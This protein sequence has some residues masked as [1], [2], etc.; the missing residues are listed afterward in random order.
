MNFIAEVADEGTVRQGGGRGR[1]QE[2]DHRPVEGNWFPE[3]QQ[4][5]RRLR[6]E[7]EDT[8]TTA[9]T[10]MTVTMT[11]R[12]EQNKIRKL[13]ETGS[14]IGAAGATTT[15]PA[16][17]D[18]ADQ[19]PQTP[20]AKPLY[21]SQAAKEANQR[22][23]Q[24]MSN[25]REDESSMPT[26]V[27]YGMM[28][29]VEDDGFFGSIHLVREE[30][31]LLPSTFLHA[32]IRS[33]NVFYRTVGF[34]DYGV[35][36]VLSNHQQPIPKASNDETR[37]EHQVRPSVVLCHPTDG[38]TGRR[39]PFDGSLDESVLNT[40]HGQ[41]C[42]GETVSKDMCIRN[43]VWTKSRT[44]TIKD[45]TEHLEEEVCLMDDKC[46]C[47]DLS[48]YFLKNGKGERYALEYGDFAIDFAQQRHKL[49]NPPYGMSCWYDDVHRRM[50][51]VV[52]ASNSM[53][54]KR[55]SWAR[56]RNPF[57]YKGLNECLLRNA[58]D[59][60]N[61]RVD[62]FVIELTPNAE[63]FANLDS[64]H[65]NIL[66]H[67]RNDMKVTN[68]LKNMRRKYGDKP[69]LLLEERLG[70]K[71]DSQLKECEYYWGGRNCGSG[72]R[73]H[74]V[75][76]PLNFTDGSCLAVPDGCN[77]VYYFPPYDKNNDNIR[78]GN[79]GNDEGSNNHDIPWGC[80]I[81]IPKDCS[82]QAGA[83]TTT[84][85]TTNSTTVMKIKTKNK[86]LLVPHQEGLR[87]GEECKGTSHLLHSLFHS[88]DNTIS[89]TTHHAD[90]HVAT[91]Q[92]ENIDNDRYYHYHLHHP[93][94]TYCT[95]VYQV[96]ILALGM[97]L[98]LLLGGAIRQQ[99]LSKSRRRQQR[100]QQE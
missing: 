23:W 66:R 76:Q 75:A 18:D 90:D 95:S 45:A 5:R 1:T 2:Q 55:D 20:L 96:M 84:T 37:N 87:D 77:E 89:M 74:F 52:N 72:F 46:R 67:L 25:E 97:T 57:K 41:G 68:R 62:A 12:N 9:A 40:D 47:N 64:N 100:R 24:E 49:G 14:G 17:R 42:R 58:N 22:L 6:T 88:I 4:E 93:K 99:R 21:S 48:P 78:Q 15:T 82:F 26:L 51:E 31:K 79:D 10:T 65:E 59:V 8:T 38:G 83:T 53:W 61:I 7:H 11:T 39:P 54:M 50:D 98:F 69:V 94:N 44:T 63:S 28:I 27:P 29:R 30:F 56:E 70:M 80:N 35:G 33:P 85:T 36:F 13:K 60:N 73:K 86:L 43:K 34:E 91:D 81:T 3:H 92:G 32:S 71:D 19:N 16:T